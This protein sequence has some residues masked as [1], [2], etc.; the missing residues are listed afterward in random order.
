MPSK[1]PSSA[2]PIVSG[3]GGGGIFQPSPMDFGP[4]TFNPWGSGSSSSSS[5]PD[6]A[7]SFQQLLMV[8]ALRKAMGRTKR[9]RAI[10][11]AIMSGSL[12]GGMIQG[13]EAVDTPRGVRHYSPPGFRT[14]DI[15]G[16]KVAV[17]K[18]IAGA[19]GLLPKSSG[20]AITK[21]E[22]RRLRRD[23]TL[24]KKVKRLAQSTGQLKCTNK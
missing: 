23:Q 7:A 17:F 18:P 21:A 13:T 4:F 1:P 20:A 2:P 12:Q 16:Q 19:L 22:M 5:I 10:L 6:R 8:M 15:L 9:G 14:V 11:E 3:P 24:V